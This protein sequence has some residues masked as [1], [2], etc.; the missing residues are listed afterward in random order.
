MASCEWTRSGLSDRATQSPHLSCVGYGL[1]LAVAAVAA[2]G[3][4]SW[5]V[6]ELDL[7]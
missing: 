3:G 1:R 2:S 4:M 6:I 7:S 5:A